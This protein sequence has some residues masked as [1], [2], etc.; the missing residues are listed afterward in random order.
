MLYILIKN[1]V[2]LTMASAVATIGLHATPS[3]AQGD[4]LPAAA[5]ADGLKPLELN[6]IV[7]LWTKHCPAP[8]SPASIRQC[9]FPTPLGAPVAL[10]GSVAPPTPGRGTMAEL[11]TEVAAETASSEPNVNVATAAGPAWRIKIQVFR[12]TKSSSADTSYTAY[13]VAI[14]ETLVLCSSYEPEI[15]SGPYFPVGACGAMNPATS[16]GDQMIGVSFYRSS[17]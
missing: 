14:N 17:R 6:G 13:Q 11:N 4:A 3:L 2:P 8:T 16:A 1:I 9:G 10:D 7:Q 5:A 12:K 15:L